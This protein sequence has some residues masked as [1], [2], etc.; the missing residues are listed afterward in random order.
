MKL[1]FILKS[2]PLSNVLPWRELGEVENGLLSHAKHAQ[3]ILLGHYFL[4]QG[5]TEQA[6]NG[7]SAEPH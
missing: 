4:L 2:C 3:E 6:V 1:A 7:Q 5:F